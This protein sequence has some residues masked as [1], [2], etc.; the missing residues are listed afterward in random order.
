M[1]NRSF[2]RSGPRGRR[3]HLG[4]GRLEGRVGQQR[5][6]VGPLRLVV[7]LGRQTVAEAVVR[8]GPVEG[9]EPVTG[10]VRV[11]VQ[12]LA[13]QHVRAG[14]PERRR[15][16]QRGRRQ[17]HRVH[18][19]PVRHRSGRRAACTSASPTTFRCRGHRRT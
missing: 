10:V 1:E 9:V 6:H 14:V 4:R 8:A 18:P 3:R 2:S 12:R 17:R 13:P 11:P 16:G 7:R 5:L 19:D 15:L